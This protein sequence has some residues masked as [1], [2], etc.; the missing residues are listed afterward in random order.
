MSRS[1]KLS[2]SVVALAL[3]IAMAVAGCSADEDP[4]GTTPSEDTSVT[5]VAPA[6]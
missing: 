2:K 5:T 1:N 3:A 4:G 6:G